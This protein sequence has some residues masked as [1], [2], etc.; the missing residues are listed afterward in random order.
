MYSYVFVPTR[1]LHV[2]FQNVWSQL[3]KAHLTQTTGG[4]L[5]IRAPWN[6]MPQLQG[7]TR[8]RWDSM[9]L[10][11]ATPSSPP[12][13]NGQ[14]GRF[15]SLFLPRGS[16]PKLRVQLKTVPINGFAALQARMVVL[17]QTYWSWLGF[18]AGPARA[19]SHPYQCGMT[20]VR[21]QSG[22]PAW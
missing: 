20:S 13:K 19:V 10:W 15:P 22:L 7:S 3:D 17:Y 8:E 11:P 21:E 4:E 2:T 14:I 16:F 9:C 18:P 1:N 12:H 5:G 6:E